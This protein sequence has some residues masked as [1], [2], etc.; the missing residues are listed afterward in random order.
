MRDD[1]IDRLRLALDGRYAVE[2]EVGRGGMSRVYAARDL[3]H[4]RRVAIKV[5]RPELAS[6]LGADRFLREIEI[7]ARLQHP[8]ILPLFDS[9][10]AADLLFY[11]M[12][13]VTGE[14]LRARLSRMG[15]LTIADA[16]R[17][18]REV[19]D[20]LGYAHREGVVHRD[21]K[22]EN[23]MLGAGHAYVMDFGIAKAL[24]EAT[25]HSGITSAGLTLGTPAYMAPEQAAAAPNVDHRA[26]I[27]ALGTLL[28]EMLAGHTPFSGSTAQRIL[29]RQMTEAPAPIQDERP[30]TP[31]AMAWGIERALE[32]DPDRRWQH[33][34][35]LMPAIESGMESARAPA[36][37]PAQRR[38][39]IAI[40][41]AGLALAALLVVMLRGRTTQGML[42]VGQN[43]Q[44]TFDS[45]L[46]LD[47]ALSPDGT[48]LAYVAGGPEGG[49][50]YVRQRDED[51]PVQA[52]PGLPRPHR[53]PKWS[54][55][56]T[57]IA[58]QTP[59]G[60]YVI[61]ALGGTAQ[62]VPG[63]DSGG[64]LFGLDW[65]P[66]GRRLAYSVGGKLYVTDAEHGG[67]RLLHEGRWDIRGASA[68]AWSPDGKAIAFI[69]ENADF[70]YG[71]V[72][73]FA[74]FA[75]TRVALVTLADSAETTLVDDGAMN[76][77]PQWLPE[78][79]GLLFVSNRAGGRDIYRLPL[80]R[81]N[82]PADSAERVTTGLG[83][84]T[85]SLDRAG[86]VLAYSRLELRSNVYSTPIPRNLTPL[87]TVAPVTMGTQVIEGFDLSPDG[88]WLAL[89]SDREGNQDIYK[90]SLVTGEL[91]RLTSDSRDDFLPTWS[92]DGRWLAFHSIRQG[93]RDVFIMPASGGATQ[94]LTDDPGQDRSPRWSPDGTRLVFESTRE[95]ERREIYM[96]Q[97]DQAGHW[98]RV[99]RITHNGGRWPEWS[100]DDSTIAYINAQGIWKIASTGGEPRLL[101]TT[102]AQ[103]VRW[104]DDGKALYFVSTANDSTAGF[105][106]IPARGGR[107]RQLLRFAPDGP[108]VRRAFFLPRDGRFYFTIMEHQSDVWSLTLGL[109]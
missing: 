55:D 107:E 65:A 21:V 80:T 53:S 13:F 94:Q 73:N 42:V 36:P 85:I 109:R 39:W 93:T 90:L 108:R 98:G 68:P 19:T 64:P 11:V 63:S 62:L 81:A 82:A 3:R 32:K 101:T 51:R 52:A 15:R 99:R 9:G 41:V 8:H 43:R 49:E 1:P 48:M 30:D 66:D 18:G 74:N 83:A 69:V 97:R 33:A 27:Y 88:Q 35:E 14:T 6:I 47:P 59:A 29:A 12:P 34:H 84:Q 4:G 71:S 104:S 23:V 105:W 96:M 24:S 7:A 20:A 78:G 70:V 38:P 102:A 31:D 103:H 37:E 95:D 57:R 40:A 89:D 25:D 54:P 17:I 28:Y 44:L 26:D 79:R 16:A 77:S 5:L 60:I 50:L 10:E 2:W 106:E 22:P 58:L 45:G 46:E 72:G 100:P 61:P 92:P 87:A 86:T 75:P 67:R 76:L 91:V 56:G